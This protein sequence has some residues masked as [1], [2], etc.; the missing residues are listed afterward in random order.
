MRAGHHAPGS[1]GHNN[2]A[3]KILC[4]PLAPPVGGEGYMYILTTRTKRPNW[5]YGGYW[6]VRI[7]AG[8]L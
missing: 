7:A 6:W 4:R 3:I 5:L 1:V 8:A 2:D